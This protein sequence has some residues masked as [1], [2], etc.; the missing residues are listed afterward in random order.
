MVFISDS[1]TVVLIGD[2]NKLYIQPDWMAKNIYEKEEIEIGVKGQGSE[3]SVSYRCN[4]VVI[5]PDQGKV[6]FSVTNTDKMTLENISHCINNFL[7]KAYTTEI[8]AYGIN[9]KFIDE[10][11][12][13][14]A[15]VVDNM[16]DASRILENGYEIMETKISRTLS[17][18]GKIINIDS[19]LVNAGLEIHFNEHH[20]NPKET[21]VFSFEV[22]NG[23]IEDC[24]EIV[25]GL[26]YE[27]EGDE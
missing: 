11:G 15:E 13:N 14:F 27:L 16:L 21:P 8:F 9:G 18:N 6:I 20:P 4:N 25:K 26:G 22:L 17:K 24:S 12:S 2:W 19:N 7:T 5:S 3:F 1:L 23:F 10:D